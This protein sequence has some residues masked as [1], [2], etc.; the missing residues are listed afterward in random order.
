MWPLLTRCF[1]DRGSHEKEVVPA[2]VEFLLGIVE[3]VRIHVVVLHFPELVLAEERI[4]LM[5][6][7]RSRREAD[8]LCL[9]YEPAVNQQ[10]DQTAWP[11][12]R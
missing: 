6:R 7:Y 1:A 10:H 5:L 4:G 9:L 11:M 2:A 3:N 12:N 8:G